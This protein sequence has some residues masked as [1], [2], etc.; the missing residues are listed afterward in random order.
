MQAHVTVDEHLLHEKFT[1]PRTPIKS[2]DFHLFVRH[3]CPLSIPTKVY[4]RRYILYARK[5]YVLENAS[6]RIENSLS[7]SFHLESFQ[8]QT[9]KET[10][11]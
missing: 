4:I 8:Q 9:K 2:T 3:F 7:F 11:T 1:I 6:C 5:E 10:L